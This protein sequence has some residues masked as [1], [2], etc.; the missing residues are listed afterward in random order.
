MLPETG[1]GDPLVQPA[2]ASGAGG[3]RGAPALP[4]QPFMEHGPNS[5]SPERPARRPTRFSRVGLD[6]VL[7]QARQAARRRRSTHGAVTDRHDAILPRGHSRGR[8]S[9][10]GSCPARAAQ[11]RCRCYS[12]PSHSHC[13]VGPCSS[14]LYAH[15]N[16]QHPDPSNG[17]DG[18]CQSLLVGFQRRMQIER[19]RAG[20]L[21]T[22]GVPVVVSRQDDV[23]SA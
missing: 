18:V 17:I 19:A 5:R 3:W 1:G 8:P 7:K 4:T 2:V 21:R 23:I 12:H 14:C 11:C 10:R 6:T 9:R 20:W 13:L 22:S 15:I 16:A